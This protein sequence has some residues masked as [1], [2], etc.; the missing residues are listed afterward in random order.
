MPSGTGFALK[1]LSFSCIPD[2]LIS[3]DQANWHF[4]ENEVG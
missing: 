4:A 1:G 3:L 2:T